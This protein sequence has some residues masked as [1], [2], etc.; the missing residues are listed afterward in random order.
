V[1]VTE[2]QTPAADPA[3]GDVRSDPLVHV[4]RGGRVESVHRGHVA[5]VD[6]AGRL[7]AWAGEPRLLVF[8]RSAYKPFQAV[9][10]VE[11]G[12]WERSGLGD[13]ALALVAGSHGGTDRH[14]AAAASILAAAGADASALR[15]GTH[16]PY[17]DATAASL[18]ARGE[19]PGPLR[20]NCSGKHAG[21]LLLASALGA[22]HSTY[23]DPEHP[24]QRRI[25]E[26]FAEI[27][28][29]AWVDPTPAI[30]GCSAPTPRMPLA[31]LAHAFALLAVGRDPAGA[32]VPALARIRDV[33]R[34]HS[35]MVAGD[36][37]LD[38]LLMRA[39]PNAVSKA[40]AEGVHATGILDR[41]IGIA[42]KI[43]DGSRRALGPA[44]TATLEAL[45][46][47]GSAEKAAL[48]QH[49]G[50]RLRNFAGLEVGAVRGVVRLRRK[51]T[52]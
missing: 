24:V 38:T 39:L 49:A 23:V 19:E 50:D 13:E 21:M 2:K 11:S 43:E 42:I 15:C 35:D 40:G 28:G 17:D 36:G 31:T 6:V 9:P 47:I 33:M 46:L 7:L 37:R 48:A 8:P 16:P 10:L 52:V 51:E 44:V 12:A 1:S 32:D 34:L 41:G 26:R 3:V 45:G 30:D 5:V 18:R 27:M 25:H 29:E 22:P 14:A 20:H 4:M